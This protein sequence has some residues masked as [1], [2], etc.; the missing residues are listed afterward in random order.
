[1]LDEQFMLGAR[2]NDE[3]FFRG[4]NTM[5]RNHKS[6]KGAQKIGAQQFVVCHFAGDVTYDVDGFVEKNKDS[7]SDL[8]TECLGSSALALIKSIYQEKLQLLESSTS[9][10]IKGNT[11]SAQFKSQLNQLIVTLSKS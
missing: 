11:L 9:K 5:L 3:G 4:I 1:M 8:I 10:S 6:F 2:G 7:V